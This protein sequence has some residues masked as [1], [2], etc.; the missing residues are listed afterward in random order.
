MIGQIQS[1]AMQ[2]TD[3]STGKT[4]QGR[5]KLGRDDF[6][7]IF[8][9]QLQYQDPLNPMEGTEFTA[10]LAQFSSLEQ[11]FNLNEELKQIRDIQAGENRF[12]ALSLIGKEIVA[13]GDKLA[14]KE[15]GGA[16]GAFEL[17][18]SADCT[19]VIED[20]SGNLVRKIPLG[21]LE[22]GRHTF[23]WDG[24]DETGARMGPGS[25]RFSIL[26]LDETGQAVSVD[27]YISGLV[28]RVSMDGNSP[29]LYVGDIPVEL[30]QVTEVKVASTQD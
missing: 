18:G 30:S 16:T 29:I 25:Y 1:T 23:Q 22:K 13:D 20:G 8:I 27:T 12:Q 26:A 10:Q 14:L 21:H 5:S 6:L 9:T 19:V 28:S 4:D 3:H 2:G 17:R 11:L 7:K 24:R 15:E